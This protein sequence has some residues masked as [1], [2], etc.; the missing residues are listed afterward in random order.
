MTS[1]T[2][3]PIIRAAG[4]GERL[5]FLGGGLHTWKLLQEDT[6]GAFFLLEDAMARGKMTP[7]HRHP[8]ADETTY[9][10]EGEILVHVDGVETHLTA[11]SV[12]F[13]PR[14]VPHAFT[15]LSEQARI[16][17]WQTPGVGQEFY[18]GASEPAVDDTVDRLDIARVQA[19]A[20]ANRGA[21]LL[22][23]PP[24]GHP[25]LAIAR[26]PVQDGPMADLVGLFERSAGRFADRVDQVGPEQWG[27]ST[28]CSE[29]DV[30]ALVNHVLGEQL[31][32]PHL[33]AGETIAEVG[34]RYEGDQLGDDPAATFRAAQ[35]QAAS[36]FRNADLDA[37][38]HLSFGDV[39]CRVYLEQMLS[40]AEVHGWDLARA[41][42]DE[43]RLDP[44]VVGAVLPGALEQEQLIR[45]SGLFGEPVAVADGADKAVRLLGLF[46]RQP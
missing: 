15:V 27:S 35:A 13:V 12:S 8:E 22:G 4:E 46:G 38:V 31:W 34:D 43:A 16:L 40:D 29:W 41:M 23:P 25:G 2:M 10:V 39:P 44:E 33:V 18:R 37:Q 30:R 6:N 28:P 3:I 5:S 9:L 11:G 21:D 45:E 20:E 17:T 36:A 42:G 14:G 19:S 7:L 26:A 32:A 24:R 1:K